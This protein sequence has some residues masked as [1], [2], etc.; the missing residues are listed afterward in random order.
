MHAFVSFA[1]I[2]SDSDPD[3]VELHVK[4]FSVGYW[5]SAET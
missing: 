4:K 2:V 1:E 3:V 5:P